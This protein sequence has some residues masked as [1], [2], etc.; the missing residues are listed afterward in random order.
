VN[1]WEKTR[2]KLTEAIDTIDKKRGQ[3]EPV[4]NPE[5]STMIQIFKG[6]RGE[7]LVEGL[8]EQLVDLVDATM[9]QN[10]TKTFQVQKKALLALADVGGEKKD[11]DP[12]NPT[13]IL[14]Y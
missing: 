11:S 4:F 14:A 6:E 12:A 2:L 1:D 5:E 8:R 9:S 10:L 3:L 13:I 7:Q